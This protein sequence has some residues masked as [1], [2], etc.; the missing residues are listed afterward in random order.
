MSEKIQVLIVDDSALMRNII[1]HIILKSA[2]LNVAAKASH[3]AI[4]IEK[5]E[6][7]S[8]DVIVCDIE[9][10]IMNGIEFL[11]I[12]REKGITIPV[13]M[14]SS[15][16]S[17]GAS[18]TMEALSLGACDFIQ[19]PSSTSKDGFDGISEQL[20]S[21]L[22][23]YGEGYRSS[24]S[25]SDLTLF[26]KKPIF[27]LRSR[28]SEV[29]KANFFTSSHNQNR[30]DRIPKTPVYIVA[31]GISTGGPYAIRRVLSALPEDFPVPIVVVQHMPVGF[32][33]E[34]AKSLN[35]VCSLEVKEASEGDLLRKG[36][37]FIAKAGKHI[38]IKH[39]SLAYT[40]SLTSAPP[41]NS[42]KPSVGKLFSSV[43]KLFGSRSLGVIMT[44]MGNDGSF[45][46]GEIHQAGGITIAQSEQSCIVYGM[47]KVAE[48]NGFIDYVLDLEDIAPKLVEIVS[49]SL[50]KD[51]KRRNG[52]EAYKT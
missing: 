31:I 30:I 17:R 9:M 5:L 43:A 48:Q 8:I 4:A 38:E 52:E 39:N 25:K 22:E 19:K 18:V 45:E 28:Q 2:K 14:L 3:G 10:P 11:K 7:L 6:S 37:V 20:I 1:S 50:G 32:T 46:I 13:V 49:L 34:F 23:R 40:I 47:P 42:H 27:S 21:L 33:E 15:L 51:I 12:R 24:Q 29:K 44:G 35:K 41:Q 36:R 16:T 26:K